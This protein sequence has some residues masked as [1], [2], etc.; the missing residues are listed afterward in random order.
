MTS[1]NHI[2]QTD[3]GQKKSSQMSRIAQALFQVRKS[4][5]PSPPC[6]FVSTTVSHETRAVL[7]HNYIVAKG[8]FVFFHITTSFLR[9]MLE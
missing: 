5:T 8:L 4:L 7:W 9:A 1:L 3:S 6:L 2:T